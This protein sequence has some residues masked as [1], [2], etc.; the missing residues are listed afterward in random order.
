MKKSANTLMYARQ[1]LYS[2]L[3]RPVV[4]RCANDTG[5]GHDWRTFNACDCVVYPV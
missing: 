4:G 1:L 5:A 3:L 2:L